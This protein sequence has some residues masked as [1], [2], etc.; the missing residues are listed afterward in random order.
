MKEKEVDKEK[1]SDSIEK[2]QQVE[3]EK[4]K[5]YEADKVEKVQEIQDEHNRLTHDQFWDKEYDLTDSQY[6]KLEIRATQ[7]IKKKQTPKKKSIVDMTPPSFSLGLSPTENEPKSKNK[8]EKGNTVI[9]DN[10]KTQMTYDAKYK[11]VCELLGT[12]YSGEPLWGC[13]EL[14]GYLVVEEL[15]RIASLSHATYPERKCFPNGI[16]V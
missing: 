1:V 11:T 10:S 15:L 5:Q 8:E 2:E 14:G 4:E 16:L 6:K 9:I 12:W 3:S 7:D 13:S